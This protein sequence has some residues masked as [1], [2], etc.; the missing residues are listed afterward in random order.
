MSIDHGHRILA[1]VR[2]A[3]DRHTALNAMRKIRGC[4]GLLGKV[5]GEIDGPEH[6]AD[7]QPL[8]SL[9]EGS[10]S[11]VTVGIQADEVVSDLGPQSKLEGMEMG[12]ADPN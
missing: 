4:L 3:G 7:P 9:P 10:Y 8:F 5:T 1:E 2:A 6:T 11:G 12:R